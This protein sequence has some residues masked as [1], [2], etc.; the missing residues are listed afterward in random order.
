MESFLI[1]FW[2]TEDGKELKI[3][4]FECMTTQAFFPHATSVSM[5]LIN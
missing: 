3:Y 5:E 2:R 1:R 4:T